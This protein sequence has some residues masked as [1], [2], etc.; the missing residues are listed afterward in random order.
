MNV[1][2]EGVIDDEKVRYVLVPIV[3]GDSPLMMQKMWVKGC[4]NETGGVWEKR[5]VICKDYGVWGRVWNHFKIWGVGVRWDSA[6]LLDISCH[7]MHNL[8]MD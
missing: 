4:L 1:W 6:L 5:G 7:L 2:G 8:A 3:R